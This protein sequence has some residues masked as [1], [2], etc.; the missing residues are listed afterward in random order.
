MRSRT[1]IG[2]QVVNVGRALDIGRLRD[3]IRGGVGDFGGEVLWVFGC[4]HD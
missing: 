4:C 3:R 1:V 2:E